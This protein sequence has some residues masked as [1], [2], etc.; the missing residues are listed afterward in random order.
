M[1]WQQGT[2]IINGVNGLMNNQT[3]SPGDSLELHLG[4][5]HVAKSGSFIKVVFCDICWMSQSWVYPTEIFGCLHISNVSVLVF[6]LL[7]WSLVSSLCAQLIRGP[8]HQAPVLNGS[9]S[10][11]I[12]ETLKTRSLSRGAD[13]RQAF[14]Q[15]LINKAGNKR[16]MIWPRQEGGRSLNRPQR[17]SDTGE[18]H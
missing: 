4:Q 5:S 7:F 15:S 16:Q 11:L 2:D 6:L 8:H 18:K 9:H 3:L 13:V 10:S 17:Q 1:Y 12:S 14:L